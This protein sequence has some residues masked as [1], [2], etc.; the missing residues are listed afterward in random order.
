MIRK[1]FI[2]YVCSVSAPCVHSVLSVTEWIFTHFL[3]LE[4]FRHF[5]TFSASSSLN[6]VFS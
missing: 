6:T 5:R 2:N 1:T 4:A 3:E